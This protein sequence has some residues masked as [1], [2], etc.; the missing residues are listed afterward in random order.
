[1]QRAAASAE[2]SSEPA[3]ATP[4]IDQQVP[5]KTADGETAQPNYISLWQTAQDVLTLAASLQTAICDLDEA[6]DPG[7]GRCDPLS[8]AEQ[9]P[10]IVKVLEAARSLELLQGE[11]RFIH[12]MASL[13]RTDDTLADHVSTAILM[14]ISFAVNLVTDIGLGRFNTSDHPIRKDRDQAYRFVKSLRS[15][16]DKLEFL[17]LEVSDYLSRV[18]R[19]RLQQQASSPPATDN[20]LSPDDTVANGWTFIDIPGGNYQD[21]KVRAQNVALCEQYTDLGEHDLLTISNHWRK[22]A[23]EFTEATERTGHHGGYIKHDDEVQRVTKLLE[24]AISQRGIEGVNRLGRCLR[25]PDSGHL[26]WALASLDELDAKLRT[27]YCNRTAPAGQTN[28][29]ETPQPP[30]TTDSEGNCPDSASENGGITPAS[31]QTTSLGRRGIRG[32]AACA[33]ELAY[34]LNQPLEAQESGRILSHEETNTIG[35]L[36]GELVHRIDTL[37]GSEGASFKNEPGR[38]L[39]VS[40]PND[41]AGKHVTEV[42]G[43]LLKNIGSVARAIVQQAAADHLGIPTPPLK[44]PKLRS[45]AEVVREIGTHAQEM[46]IVTAT[47]PLDQ[48]EEPFMPAWPEPVDYDLSSPEKTYR[49]AKKVILLIGQCRQLPTMIPFRSLLDRELKNA[50]NSAKISLGLANMFHAWASGDPEPVPRDAANDHFTQ[51]IFDADR[52]WYFAYFLA[53]CSEPQ[54]DMETR[55]TIGKGVI[56]FA[57]HV[58][59]TSNALGSVQP[60]LDWATKKLGLMPVTFQGVKYSNPLRAAV[61]FA[62]AAV[63]TF[64]KICDPATVVFRAGLQPRDEADFL[65]RLSENWPLIVEDLHKLENPGDLREIVRSVGELAR[66]FSTAS[67]AARQ[68]VGESGMATSPDVPKKPRVPMGGNSET[69]RPKQRQYKW[70]AEAMLLVNEHPEW[71]DAEIARKVGKDKSRLSRS[72]P[73]QMA[74][75]LARQ[76]KKDMPTGYKDPATGDFEAWEPGLFMT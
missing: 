43:K 26:H 16:I 55:A 10:Y 27:E 52:T 53:G 62:A 58:E 25:R 57:K 39:R 61:E 21:G 3:T 75:D 20:A 60:A 70:L 19:E 4:T 30:E 17:R 48:P 49:R 1:M 35:L 11:E 65:R 71:S 54:W 74:A 32:I 5:N 42:L 46:L 6:E 66:E 69:G 63:L 34:R 31:S 38:K 9:R 23:A 18:A 40:G 22:M 51:A 44:N 64:L 68:T 12:I 41:I 2:P 8:A 76:P 45:K 24:T 37:C 56:Q 50:M 73:Y 36:I 59:L 14:V 47:W 67:E 72:K 7:Y 29:L 28:A 15:E 13:G 33:Q